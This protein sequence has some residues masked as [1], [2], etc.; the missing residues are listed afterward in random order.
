MIR[1]PSLLE[2]FY[3]V[4]HVDRDKHRFGAAGYFIAYYFELS[5]KTLFVPERKLDGGT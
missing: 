2:S 1:L 5:R 4:K 3:D